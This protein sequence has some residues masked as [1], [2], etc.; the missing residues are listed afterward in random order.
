MSFFEFNVVFFVID[1]AVLY[2]YIKI[3]K[4]PKCENI[5]KA[6]TYKEMGMSG[7][8]LIFAWIAYDLYYGKSVEILGY[9][10]LILSDV[11]LF[12]YKDTFYCRHCMK[13][14]PFSEEDIIK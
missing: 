2:F 13:G 11:Y 14:I 1:F 3:I 9:S 6:V 5:S 8:A 10:L 7:L 4:C 12:L